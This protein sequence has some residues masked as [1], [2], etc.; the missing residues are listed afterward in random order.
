MSA[1]VSSKKP[2]VKHIF[3]Y[4]NGGRCYLNSWASGIEGST[5]I[6]MFLLPY[7]VIIT[8]QTSL[9]VKVSLRFENFY[10][11]YVTVFDTLFVKVI[12]FAYII[13]YSCEFYRNYLIIK[14]IYNFYFF[15]LVLFSKTL[16]WKFCFHGKQ[17]IKLINKLFNLCSF[18]SINTIILK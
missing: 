14:G 6:T 13:W 3:L 4:I 8:T 17:K 9:N 10:V 2:C 11:L 15:Y 16:I 5:S 18:I 7:S 12:N 1:H